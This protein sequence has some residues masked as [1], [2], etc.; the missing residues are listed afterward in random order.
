MLKYRLLEIDIDG[1]FKSMLLLKKKKYA[2]LT[3]EKKG[4][5]IVTK[6]EFKGLDIVRRDWSNIARSTGEEILRILLHE[7]EEDI[8]IERIHDHLELG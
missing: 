3:A 5:Q 2:A 4:D 8:A 1:A 7:T 6:E